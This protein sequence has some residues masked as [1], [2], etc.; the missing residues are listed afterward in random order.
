MVK[1]RRLT[2]ENNYKV[3][4][5]F[6]Q[7]PSP[8]CRAPPSSAPVLSTTTKHL[9][10]QSSEVGQQPTFAQTQPSTQAQSKLYTASCS[11][12]LR[13]V[14]KENAPPSTLPPPPKMRNPP[15]RE[16]EATYVSSSSDAPS[17]ISISSASVISIGNSSSVV[18]VVRPARQDRR[19][20]Q[21]FNVASSSPLT[22][23]RRSSPR[24]QASTRRP[25]R[26]GNQNLP[27]SPRKPTRKRKKPEGV[28]SDDGDVIDLEAMEE[29]IVVARKPARIDVSRYI[30]P[31]RLP[32]RLNAL[33]ACDA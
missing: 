20:L 3:T 2:T 5:F 6:A 11:S 31:P 18:E 4:D 32:I 24:L 29:V 13:S 19:H 30:S 17:H 33:S 14:K 25:S 21:T 15:P 1:A 10:R 9:G 28:Q 27:A 16:R 8:S 7:Q 12:P 22:S 26:T 23:Q